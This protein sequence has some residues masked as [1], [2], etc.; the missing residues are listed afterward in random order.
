MMLESEVLKI[1]NRHTESLSVDQCGCFRAII[2]LLDDECLP[3]ITTTAS[4]GPWD[5]EFSGLPHRDK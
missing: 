3:D 1:A 4:F 2:D 5:C